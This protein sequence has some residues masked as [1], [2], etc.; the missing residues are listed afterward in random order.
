MSEQNDGRWK[1]PPSFLHSCVFISCLVVEI[2]CIAKKGSFIRN[3]L[4]PEAEDVNK[5]S[6]A[7]DCFFFL[8]HCVVFIYDLIAI[9]TLSHRGHHSN[10][11][12]ND[13]ISSY[14]IATVKPHINLIPIENINGISLTP[15]EH[16]LFIDKCIKTFIFFYSEGDYPYLM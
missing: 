4:Q 16:M 1:Y 5:C 12:Y 6:A 8:I 2:V 14:R 10:R 11:N 15:F 7:V 13:R 9:Q 3:K